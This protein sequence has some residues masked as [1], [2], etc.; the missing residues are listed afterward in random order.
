MFSSSD[1]QDAL[2]QWGSL[3]ELLADYR[4]SLFWH[5]H[6]ASLP[7]I[8]AL[9]RL[10]VPSG[11]SFSK[12]EARAKSWRRRLSCARKGS[13]LPDPLRRPSTAAD[14]VSP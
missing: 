8:K 4:P 9:E 14:I 5:Q 1:K 10:G 11:F 3:R 6:C 12:G 7:Q 2:T 13:D